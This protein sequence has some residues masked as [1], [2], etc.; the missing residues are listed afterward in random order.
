[1]SLGER[2]VPERIVELAAIHSLLVPFE[3]RQQLAS[4]RLPYFASVI[5]AA[6]E[7]PCLKPRL[8]TAVFVEP[9]TGQR[10]HVPPQLFME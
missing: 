6:S 8:P 5:V 2:R 10:L 1:M 3:A 9:A 7:Q 4:L